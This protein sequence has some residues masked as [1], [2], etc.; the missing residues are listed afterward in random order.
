MTRTKMA[1][2]GTSEL[3]PER[4]RH[5][6]PVSPWPRRVRLFLHGCAALAYTCALIAVI[7]IIALTG[8]TALGTVPVTR[9]LP[10]KPCR[11]RRHFSPQT[12]MNRFV[13]L[14]LPVLSLEAHLGVTTSPHAP[15]PTGYVTPPMYDRSPP[16]RLV[17]SRSRQQASAT[18]L[19]LTC[20][21]AFQTC[22][23][24]GNIVQD[25]SEKRAHCR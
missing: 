19:P 4:S 5:G 8:A 10:I 17:L 6:G 11:W 1:G 7:S 9:Q 14:N 22:S 12:R 15:F 16:L 24:L 20:S 21:D 13:F 25:I 3:P 2:N 18:S 23:R